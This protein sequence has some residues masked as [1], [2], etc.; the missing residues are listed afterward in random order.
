[1]GQHQIYNTDRRSL[2]N[3]HNNLLMK[4]V[5]LEYLSDKFAVKKEYKET[6]LRHNYLLKEVYKTVPDTQVTAVPNDQ[7]KVPKT[8]IASGLVIYIKGYLY[9]NSVKLG[10]CKQI[11]EI[12]A[13]QIECLQTFIQSQPLKSI[14]G[15]TLKQVQKLQ[16]REDEQ[17]RKTKL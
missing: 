8:W 6:D 16:T 11:E 14:Q 4:Q 17:Y 9:I 1:M 12:L 15:L 7:I 2:F 3:K 5:D 13:F 10:V